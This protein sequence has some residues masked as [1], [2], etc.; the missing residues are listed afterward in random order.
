MGLAGCSGNG[1]GGDGG[2]GADGGDGGD[3]G[4]GDGGDGGDVYPEEGRS[5]EYI[6]PFSEGGG[7]DTYARQIMGKTTEMLGL[8]LQVNN[9]PGGASLRGTEQIVNGN[10]DGYEM[11][12][13]NPPSTPL[14]YLV[15]EPDFDL[16]EVK[17]VCTYA[18]TPYVIIANTDLEVDGFGDLVDRYQDG[19]FSA[20]GGCQAQGG[21]N[22]VG[23]L[24]MRNQMGLEWENYVGYDG[25]APAGQAVAS[26]EIPATIGSDLAIEGVVESGR[27]EVVAVMMSQGSTV[28]PDA[29]SLTDQGFDNIDYIG[30]LNRGMYMPPGV[31]DEKIQT[32]SSAIEEAIQSDELQQWSEE[33]GNG[34]SYGP[35]ENADALVQDSIEQ[36]PQQ[37]DIE[38]IRELAQE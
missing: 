12:G 1:D 34:L 30:G 26:G 3:G 14:S 4:G 37:V 21:L 24:V 25:C 5:I 10:P 29:E 6:V 9:V 8:N 7:T 2:D 28:F 17:G 16:T 31:D 13:F 20:I 18:T 15:F 33:S 36:I 22:H 23:S 35:P 38:Q 19:E 32:L 27:A 11:G